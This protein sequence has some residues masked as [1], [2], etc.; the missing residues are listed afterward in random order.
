VTRC[1][2]RRLCDNKRDTVGS[3]ARS[4]VSAVLAELST[5]DLE[6]VLSQTCQTSS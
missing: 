6:L 2:R 1:A 4:A 3:G 5:H